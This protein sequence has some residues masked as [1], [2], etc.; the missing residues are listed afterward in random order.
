MVIEQAPYSLV[1]ISDDF[2]ESISG[3]LGNIG[4][5]WG[6]RPATSL[7]RIGIL[8]EVSVGHLSLDILCIAVC[9][10]VSVNRTQS[11]DSPGLAPVVL[12]DWFTCR[13]HT[14]AGS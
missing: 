5:F 13:Q 11:M 2:S 1:E 8:Q 12:I 4:G 6:E 3:L 14:A 10:D 7:Q 9:V